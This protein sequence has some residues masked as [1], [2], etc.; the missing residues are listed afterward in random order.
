[1]ERT[2]I[3]LKPDAVRRGLMG[4]I[5]SRIEKKGFKITQMKMTILEREAVEEH[6][7][8]V[9]GRSFFNDMISY[10]CSSPAVLMVVEGED[11]VAMMRTMIGK[12]MVNEAA[13][14]TVRGDLGYNKNENLIHASDLPENAE[15]EFARFF[16][17]VKS[18]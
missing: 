18:K 11:V 9:K 7:A 6:Y 5:I 17:E 2:I 13:P 16:P 14:G 15:I 12:T 3:I 8:H 1:M 4:E 10:M